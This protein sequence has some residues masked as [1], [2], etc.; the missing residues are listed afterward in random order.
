M[1]QTR[2]EVDKKVLG[3]AKEAGELLAN[4]KYG[5]AWS[6]MRQLHGLVK[7]KNALTLPDSMVEA[8]EKHIK[9]Y[10]H[11]YDV[12]TQARKAMTAIGRKMG[13]VE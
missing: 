6:V 1:A 12:I 2:N 11:Q 5:E 10:Y 4:Y 8:L 3:L 9:D 7:K 13:Q